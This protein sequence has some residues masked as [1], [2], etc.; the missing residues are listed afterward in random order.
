MNERIRRSSMRFSSS[1]WKYTAVS[2]GTRKWALPSGFDRHVAQDPHRR[3]V[4]QV[5]AF[6]ARAAVAMVLAVPLAAALVVVGPADR[7]GDAQVA[8]PLRGRALR[9]RSSRR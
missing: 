7:L 9:S 4:D 5:L 8:D 3:P 2:A 1:S 6:G